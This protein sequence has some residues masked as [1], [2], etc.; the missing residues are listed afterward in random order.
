M[1]YRQILMFFLIMVFAEVNAQKVTEN[2]SK[3]LIGNW[4]AYESKYTTEKNGTSTTQKILCNSCPKVI[5][6]FENKLQNAT[7]IKP[8]GEKENYI[9]NIEGN[10]ITFY[11]IDARYNPN[12]FFNLEYTFKFKQKKKY[13][14]LEFYKQKTKGSIILRR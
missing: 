3:N 6:T 9:W 10:K 1:K 12:A 5:F 14:E 4:T 11:N 8:N 2:S 13:I 7:V